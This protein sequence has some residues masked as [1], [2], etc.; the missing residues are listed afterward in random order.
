MQKT[1]E[2]KEKGKAT[3]S[4]HHRGNK[5]LSTNRNHQSDLFCVRGIGLIYGAARIRFAFDGRAD[6][7]KIFKIQRPDCFV[8]VLEGRARLTKS[9]KIKK[10][11]FK[12]CVRASN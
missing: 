10:R 2:G 12:H 4:D 9:I 1:R 7:E 11:K 8:F 5:V 6:D 3:D